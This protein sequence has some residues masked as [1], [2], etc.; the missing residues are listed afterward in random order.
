MDLLRKYENYKE[1]DELQILEEMSIANESS[2]LDLLDLVEQQVIANKAIE[3]STILYQTGITYGVESIDYNL[4]RLGVK[5]LEVGNEDIKSFLKKTWRILKN[6]FIKSIE[7]TAELLV[8]I[9]NFLARLITGKVVFLSQLR[10]KIEAIKVNRL[11]LENPDVDPKV[12]DR[13]RDRLIGVGLISGE[14]TYTG[15][16]RYFNVVKGLDVKEYNNIA[17]IASLE[18]ETNPVTN[19]IRSF[20]QKMTGI[21]VIQSET[22]CNSTKTEIFDKI[23]RSGEEI[24]SNNKLIFLKRINA[25]AKII[26]TESIE[27][28]DEVEGV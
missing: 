22:K 14:I 2:E 10:N 13:I 1:K 20:L 3:M 23:I 12:I 17:L 28:F 6:A 21:Q 8:K 5:D 19:K 18:N 7:L 9:V 15:L 26:S 16:V 27:I 11:Y 25:G 4:E 24:N